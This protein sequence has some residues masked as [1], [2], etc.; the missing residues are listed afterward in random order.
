MSNLPD[1][2]ATGRDIASVIRMQMNAPHD[3]MK[4]AASSTCSWRP[5]IRAMVKSISGP[6][7]ES[8]SHR[9]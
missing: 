5:V 7:I 6:V 1:S 3:N 2:T 4:T 8:S 9:Q